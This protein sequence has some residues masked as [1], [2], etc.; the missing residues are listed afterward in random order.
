MSSSPEI[1]KVETPHFIINGEKASALHVADRD[2]VF[3]N[4]GG[5]VTDAI[6]WHESWVESVYR[7]TDSM[8]TGGLVVDCGANIGA[9]TTLCLAIHPDE[10]VIAI[11]PVPDNLA[12]LEKN[13]ELNGWQDRV[14]VM[15][16]AVGSASGWCSMASNGGAAHVV[17]GR[18]VEVRTLASLVVGA[19]EI[20]ILKCDIEGAEWDLFKYQ[21]DAW[22]IL[23]LTRWLVMEW[24]SVSPNVLGGFLGKLTETHAFS[25]IGKPKTGG[26]LYAHR[27]DV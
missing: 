14:T 13:I 7:L 12:L 16:Y 21:S 17:E 24:H 10:H 20:D 5:A 18:D 19:E 22:G 1:V 15:P 23:A 6:V 3:V 9:F 2:A 25:I 11:E 4:K 26:M 27:H 8:L